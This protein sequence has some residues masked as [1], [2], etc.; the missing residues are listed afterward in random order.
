MKIISGAVQIKAS[1]VN[2]DE[3]ERGIRKLL[4]F[5]HTYGHAIEKLSS[6]AHGEAVSIG[7]VIAANI[8]CQKGLLSQKELDRI[9]ALLV[10]VGLPVEIDLSIDRLLDVILKDKKKQ[11]DTIDF[12]L[13]NEIGKGQIVNMKFSEII[14]QV[15]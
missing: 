14:P 11:H 2:L 8:S 13:L 3:K 9:I 7:M 6:L 15:I 4:N 12:I 10:K 1:I 5:G